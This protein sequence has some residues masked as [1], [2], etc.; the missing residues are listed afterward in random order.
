MLQYNDEE[1]AE[2]FYVACRTN[3]NETKEQYHNSYFQYTLQSLKAH[4]W[5][6]I[7]SV[8]QLTMIAMSFDLET[9]PRVPVIVAHNTLVKDTFANTA[10][11]LEQMG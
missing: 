8:D 4:V 3:D 5:S 2:K 11:L 6:M 10:L 9:H 7:N 1:A